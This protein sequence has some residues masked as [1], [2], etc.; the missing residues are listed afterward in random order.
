MLR[1]IRNTK[2][3]IEAKT[4]RFSKKLDVACKT[5][6]AHCKCKHFSQVKWAYQ[7]HSNILEG[8]ALLMGLRWLGRQRKMKEHQVSALVYSQVVFHMI[9]KGRSGALDNFAPSAV[10]DRCL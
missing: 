2:I 9:K 7:K 4:S 6:L 10:S 1:C 3:F 8:V 5:K